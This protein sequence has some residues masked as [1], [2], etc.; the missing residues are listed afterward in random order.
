MYDA[1]KKSIQDGVKDANSDV[2]KAARHL[3]WVLKG[4]PSYEHKMERVLD[5]MD[6]S[7]RK[8]VNQELQNASEDFIELLNNPT[9]GLDDATTEYVHVTPFEGKRCS[10]APASE[11]VPLSSSLERPSSDQTMRRSTKNAPPPLPSQRHVMAGPGRV[12]SSDGAKGKQSS[13]NALDEGSISSNGSISASSSIDELDSMHDNSYNIR[14]RG[15][16]STVG[17]ARRTTM[18]PAR[19]IRDKGDSRHSGRMLRQGSGEEAIPPAP[20]DMPPPAPPA[21]T[22]SNSIRNKR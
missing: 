13:R 7:T 3:F 22:I 15:S 16:K 19:V 8:H 21:V 6:A 2:R 5:N 10:N 9:G 11:N 4:T 12:A 20:L 18:A 17:G 1:F 14:D